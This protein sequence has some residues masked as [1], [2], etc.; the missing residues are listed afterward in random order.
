MW[1]YSNEK[2]N[3]KGCNNAHHSL[4]LCKKHFDKYIDNEKILK[5]Q[6]LLYKDEFGDTTLCEK[7]KLFLHR[8]FH[9]ITTIH[10]YYY[11]HFPL[12][13][14]FIHHF[15]RFNTYTIENKIELIKDFDFEDNNRLLILKNIIDDQDVNNELIDYLK[16]TTN[17][18][19]LKYAFISFI[20]LSLS[21]SYT[22]ITNVKLPFNAYYIDIFFY[23]ILLF[24]I[25]YFGTKQVGSS[26]K[27]YLSAINNKLFE[28]KS[29][30]NEYIKSIKRELYY[31]K[32]DDEINYSTTGW[33][34]G[35]AISSIV[36]TFA[37]MNEIS[38]QYGLI[39]IL[40]VSSIFILLSQSL[41]MLISARYILNT[42]VK[43]V[44]DGLRIDLYDLTKNIGQIELKNNLRNAFV[45]NLSVVLLFFSFI[46][47]IMSYS[48]DIRFLILLILPIYTISN[49]KSLKV[50][51]KINK[52]LKSRFIIAKLTE[53][54]KINKSKRSDRFEK[55]KFIES[56]KFN[57]LI[58]W[59]LI[60]RLLIVFA[61]NTFVILK[62][63]FIDKI[64]LIFHIY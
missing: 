28:L 45:F 2:C 40:I 22:I 19:R 48:I 9:L 63:I 27:L 13:T 21:L 49:F 44:P 18:N 35:L 59:N 4:F 34:F 43:I 6:I 17:F 3:I 41:L 14:L 42:L 46:P 11:E 31:L 52:N 33:I 55:Y 53:L 26:K 38:L 12:E 62:D 16:K 50:T 51:T 37:K 7:L 47:K 15:Y 61:S 23:S 39:A 60:L 24:L 10:V 30:N 20:V 57:F 25:V 5:T 1:K 54:S 32:G 29:K 56:L 36:F 58:N 64:K 8:V